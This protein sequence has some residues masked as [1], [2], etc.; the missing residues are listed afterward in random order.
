M[1]REVWIFSVF[2]VG[3]QV[4]SC[5]LL[6]VVTCVELYGIVCGEKGLLS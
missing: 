5:R 3:R 6:C 4:C 2:C 1:G